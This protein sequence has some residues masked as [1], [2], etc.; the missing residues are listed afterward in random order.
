MM[1]KLL[2]ILDMKLCVAERLW[3]TY[4]GY[5]REEYDSA[6]QDQFMYHYYMD[7]FADALKGLSTEERQ[8]FE[9][10]HNFE[11]EFLG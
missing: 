1:R 11:L 8:M 9:D 3:M 7:K 10:V 2:Q 5:L 4:D 6:M